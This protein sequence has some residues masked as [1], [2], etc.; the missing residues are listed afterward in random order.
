M[1][2]YWLSED[3]ALRLTAFELGALTAILLQ[4]R[5]VGFGTAL[6]N[7][8]GPDGEPVEIAMIDRLIEKA[9]EVINQPEGDK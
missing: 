3:Y 1:S 6:M 2:H 7:K 8:P 4:A 9:A 5:H